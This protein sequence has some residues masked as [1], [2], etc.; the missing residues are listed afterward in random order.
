MCAFVWGG[1]EGR[2]RPRTAPGVPAQASSLTCGRKEKDW[3]RGELALGCTGFEL[4]VPKSTFSRP[5][6]CETAAREA[7]CSKTM[8]CV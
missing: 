4:S 7:G 1:D 3:L 8:E 5:F 2:L 6:G